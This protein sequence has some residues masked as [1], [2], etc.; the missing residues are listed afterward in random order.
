MYTSLCLRAFMYHGNF[1]F[2]IEKEDL[3][4]V[5]KRASSPEIFGTTTDSDDETGDLP[6]LAGAVIIEFVA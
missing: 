4:V 2:A 5:K 3:W 1:L 6:S